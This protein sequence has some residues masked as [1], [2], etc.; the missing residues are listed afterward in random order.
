MD[1]HLPVMHMLYLVENFTDT[2]VVSLRDGIFPA[3][4]CK[5]ILGFR[6]WT[7]MLERSDEAGI[8][9]HN[10]FACMLC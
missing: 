1:Y 10:T 5:I 6:A 4:L 2:D 3:V 7:R 9:L 8:I